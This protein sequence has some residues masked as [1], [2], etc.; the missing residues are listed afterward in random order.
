MKT[1]V[2]IPV[3]ILFLISKQ[4]AA[5][6]R[7][8]LSAKDAVTYALKNN[9]QVKNAQLDVNIQE[10]T[11]KEITAAAYPQIK[12][13]AN[14]SYYPNIPVQRFPNFIAAA[15]YGVLTNEGVK[16]GSGSPIVMPS[17][18]GFINAAFGS[19]FV[20]TAGVSLQQLLFDGQVFVGLQARR[21]S[22]EWQQKNVEVTQEI[23]KSNIYKVYYQLAA[24]KYQINILDSN[25]ARLQKLERDT[26]IIYKNGFA[27]K[28]DVDKIVVQLSNLQTEKQKV[29]TT[30]EN[31]YFGLKVL[32]GMPVRDSLVLTDSISYEDITTGVLDATAYNYNDRKEYQYAE[33]TRRLNEFNVK[34]FK[35]TAIPTVALSAI[36]NYSAQANNLNLF[37]STW[38]PVTVIGLNINVPIFDGFAR[39]ARI[40]KAKLQV[41]QISNR[42]EELKLTIDNEVQQAL[43]NYNSAIIT[44]ENQRRNMEL[45][46]KVYDQTKKKYQAGIGSSTEMQSANVDLG[47]A[48]SNFIAA[49]YDAIITKIDF[50]KATG[51]LD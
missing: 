32:L 48:Q 29:L 4:L 46:E 12:G 11:N 17:D 26:R 9:N 43:R 7:H 39:I 34:R 40:N 3:I 27:E 42:I 31:G 8:A 36:H 23:I 51:K 14:S 16:D 41:D 30:I 50:L 15:T 19:K 37:K 25:V 49:T 33:L 22:M 47:I 24:S 13:T 10:Q 5:Q 6:Q 21:T 45:A 35:L 18:F 28:L 20:T 2:Y 1:S 44:L 38:N